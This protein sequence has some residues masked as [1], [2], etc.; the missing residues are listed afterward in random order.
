MFTPQ[1]SRY[2]ERCSPYCVFSV[3]RCLGVQLTDAAAAPIQQ[4]R[5]LAHSGKTV[6]PPILG[7]D[8]QFP[9]RVLAERNHVAD[10]LNLPRPAIR[11]RTVLI[12]EASQPAA[13]VV[14][15]EIV[16]GNLRNSPAA[17]YITADHRARAVALA[18]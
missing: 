5:N 6:Y 17:V 3:F 9:R 11:R 7:D 10:F 1:P 12:P 18:D 2:C 13:A 16:S 4:A 14:G 8:V 15:V